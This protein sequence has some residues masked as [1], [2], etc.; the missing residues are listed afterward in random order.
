MN[1]QAA[2]QI[3]VLY[4]PGT[5]DAEDPEVIQAMA[6]ARQ[7]PELAQWFEQHCAFQK[8]MRAKLRAIEVPAQLK[9]ALQARRPVVVPRVWWRNPVWLAAAA[10]VV[11]L[12]AMAGFWLRQGPTARFANYQQRMVSAS[13]GYNMDVTT[14][15][16][17][18]LRRA[19]A[20]KG[21]P[22]DYELTKGLSELPLEGGTFLRWHNHPVSMVCFKRGDG[23]PIYLFVLKR[24]ALRNPPPGQPR[25]ARMSGFQT[26]SW[27][28]G[29]KTYFLVGPDEPGFFQKYF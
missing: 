18:E 11:V 19:F 7:D 16:M 9:I 13:R 24:L 6:V 1:S 25:V 15:D 3:L 27:T 17:R 12:L 4:R 5:P 20:A 23:V 21:A 22:A 14:N 2:K 26:V 8:E 10:S 29:D 28:R